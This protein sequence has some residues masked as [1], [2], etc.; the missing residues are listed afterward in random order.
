MTIDDAIEL[1]NAEK[2]KGVT[3]V[4]LSHWTAQDFGLLELDASWP[5]ITALVEDADWARVN[6]HVEQLVE[7]AQQQYR[8]S[9]LTK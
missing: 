8:G 6:D 3:H 1:L 4:I 7:T 5:D 9:N 2:K